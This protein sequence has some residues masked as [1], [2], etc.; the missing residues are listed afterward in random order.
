P[1]LAD[2]IRVRGVAFRNDATE[3]YS[4]LV[5]N[6]L[7]GNTDD[8]ARN[9]AFIVEGANLRLA[10][11]Y[12]LTPFPRAGGEAGHGMKL[13]R[14]NNL[15]RIRLCL[16]TAPDFGLTADRARAIVE[17]QIAGIVRHFAPLCDEAGMTPTMRRQLQGRA[18]LNPDIFTG[19]PELAPEAGW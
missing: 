16:D 6:V 19:C 3:L 8:H 12:D 10:P 17:R 9:H 4:R 5:Y 15:S 14:T 11:A 1:D 13:T 7:I 2:Q 18:V